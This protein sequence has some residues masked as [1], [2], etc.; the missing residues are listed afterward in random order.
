MVLIVGKPIQKNNCPRCGNINPGVLSRQ[1][2]GRWK[3]EYLCLDC[4][5]GKP[6]DYRTPCSCPYCWVQSKQ[7]RSPEDAPLLHLLEANADSALQSYV[8]GNIDK[9][10]D[11]L[12][13]ILYV[14]R[15]EI[16]KYPDLRIDRC[17]F[18]PKGTRAKCGNILIKGE[19]VTHGQQLYPGLDHYF[20]EKSELRIGGTKRDV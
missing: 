17:K 6:I 3:G 10:M 1:L 18:I 15:K 8:A 20:S 4:E 19:C 12:S 9:M 14:T 7:W 16:M 13:R 2:K 5:N 11:R